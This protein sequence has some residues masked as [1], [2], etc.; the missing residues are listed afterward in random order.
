[1]GQNGVSFAIIKRMKALELKSMNYIGSSMNPTLRPGVRLDVKAY[2]RQKTRRG[3][4]IVFIP[5]GRD[6]KVV[7]RVISVNS[8]GVRTRGDNCNQEDDWVLSREHIIGRV[9]AAQRG[10]RRWR[11]FGGPMG[12]LFA[13]VLRVIHA[14]D[15]RVSCLLRPAYN[16]LAK[17]VPA[18]KLRVSLRGRFWDKMESVLP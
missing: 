15:S 5:P 11:V 17:T 2:Q 12:Q 10:K 4:V 7:H 16:E 3:D 18:F 8:L 1:M 6:S 9:V 14:I 13:A